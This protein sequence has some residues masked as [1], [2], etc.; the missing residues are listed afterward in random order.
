MKIWVVGRG[1]PTPENGGWGSFEL[2]QAKMLARRGNKVAYVALT[3]SFR[4]RGDKRG[5]THKRDEGVE[6]FASSFPYFPG[7]S[8]LHITAVE[9]MLWNRLLREVEAAVD[10]PDVVHVHYPSMLGGWRAVEAYRAK[11]AKVFVTEHWNRVIGQTLKQHER[12]RLACYC[13]SSSCV[14]CVSQKLLDATMRYVK[15]TVPTKVVPN[16]LGSE[17]LAGL[18]PSTPTCNSTFT[19]AC[20]GRLAPIKRFGDVIEA[21]LD[22][23]VEEQNVRLLIIGSGEEF[24]RLQ[25]KSKGDSR[26]V[27][28]G[29][30]A[31][32]EVAR[33]LSQSDALVSYSEIET[34]C[35]PVIEAWACGKPVIMTDDAPL[36]PYVKDW[37]GLTVKNGDEQSLKGALRAMLE[38]AA[39]Y[40]SNRI[41]EFAITTFGE[42]AVYSQ[43]MELYE[44]C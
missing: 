19:F 32:H 14:I 18:K 2:E 15:V 24:D 10:L 21:F 8:G 23:F 44:R 6:V 4:S 40:D 38:N 37:L 26:I 27:F 16:V 28:A 43:L 12:E 25:K 13:Q 5:L 17:F 9:D 22:E 7:K 11:G 30:L 42:E 1:Y 3:L 39:I 31:Q 41:A 34:F 36:G 29:R 33:Q 20:V 35:V